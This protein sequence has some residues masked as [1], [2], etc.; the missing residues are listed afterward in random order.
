MISAVFGALLSPHCTLVCFIC[1]YKVFLVLCTRLVL[2]SFMM[3]N[4]M[5]GGLYL[6]A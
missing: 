5:E 3:N 2:C 4:G 6:K 1:Y